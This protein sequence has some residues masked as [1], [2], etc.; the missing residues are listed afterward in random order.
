MPSQH[1]SQMKA[2]PG[3]HLQYKT[4]HTAQRNIFISPYYF[5][6]AA[7]YVYVCVRA[8]Y[9]PYWQELKCTRQV[10]MLQLEQLE[11]EIGG[12]HITHTC[13][14]IFHIFEAFQF[15]IVLCHSCGYGA[16]LAL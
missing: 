7:V 12:I 6:L 2:F 1:L 11:G 10:K 16:E 5:L 15:E 4:H 8:R 9:F 13:I 14:L 3:E